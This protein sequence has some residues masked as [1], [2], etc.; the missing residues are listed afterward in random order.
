MRFWYR[1]TIISER[2]ALLHVIPVVPA[3]AGI[4]GGDGHEVGGEGAGPL[5]AADGDNLVAQRLAEGLQ[6]GP[7]ELRK[8]V[9]EEDAPLAQAEFSPGLIVGDEASILT[10]CGMPLDVH[11]L[12]DAGKS[13][14]RE[15]Y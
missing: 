9:E 14:I 7:A 13:S 2:R 1:E 11:L 10:R 4:L 5:S 12:E 6:P 3:R 8:L 15:D